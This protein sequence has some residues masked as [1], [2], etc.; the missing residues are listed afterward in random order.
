MRRVSSLPRVPERLSSSRPS[1]CVFCQHSSRRAAPFS[2]RS[3][4][5][6]RRTEEDTPSPDFLERTRRRLWGTDAPPGPKDPY[7]R[8]AANAKSAPSPLEEGEDGSTADDV[9]AYAA[10]EFAQQKTQMQQSVEDAPM[11]QDYIP[12]TTW[13]G[14]EAVGG[15]TEWD[16][17]KRFEG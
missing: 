3:A 5:S 10:A 8:P 11:H 17:G 14:L 13:D 7:A 1:I 12:A 16:R 2:T 6:S 9:R 4:R 15:E